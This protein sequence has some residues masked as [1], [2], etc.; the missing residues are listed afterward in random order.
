[1]AN[2]NLLTEMAKNTIEINKKFSSENILNQWI[3]LFDKF[4]KKMKVLWF[5]PTPSLY[6][7]KRWGHNGGGWIASLQNIITLDDQIELA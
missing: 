6:D 7:S 1:M 5:S 4:D 3:D 2:D